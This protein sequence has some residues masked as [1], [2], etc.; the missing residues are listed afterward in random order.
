MWDMVKL[1]AKEG[2]EYIEHDCIHLKNM[3]LYS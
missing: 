2:G 3:E 1:G